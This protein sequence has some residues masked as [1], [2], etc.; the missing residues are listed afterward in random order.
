MEMILWFGGMKGIMALRSDVFPDAVPPTTSMLSSYCMA[1]H[2]IAAISV[3][4]VLTFGSI[5]FIIVQGDL[6]NLLI[7]IVLPFVDMGNSVAFTL[8]P[9]ERCASISG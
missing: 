2:R 7:V 1:S 4:I 8:S 3:D 5:M 6:E 9:V